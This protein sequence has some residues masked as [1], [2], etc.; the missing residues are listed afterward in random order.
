[1]RLIRR[2]RPTHCTDAFIVI[3]LIFVLLWNLQKIMG[4]G[5]QLPPAVQAFGRLAH[6]DQTWS[7]FCGPLP[8]PSWF[9][10]VGT[11]ESGGQVDLLRSGAPVSWAKPR[12]LGAELRRER[13]WKFLFRMPSTREI[14]RYYAGYTCRSWNARHHGELRLQSFELVQVF[15][16]A[17]PGDQRQAFRKKS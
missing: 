17:A 3:C 4:T 5:F 8:R 1:M 2:I 9:V 14:P 15:D 11:L 13:W 6:L 10:A 16:S 12:R 7:M